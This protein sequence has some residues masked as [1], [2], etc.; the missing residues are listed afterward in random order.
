VALANFVGPGLQLT[1]PARLKVMV[2]KTLV[3]IVKWAEKGEP[4]EL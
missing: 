2:T 4:V 3:A 1:D